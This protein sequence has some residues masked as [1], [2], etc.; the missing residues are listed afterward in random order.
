MIN[1]EYENHAIFSVI[2]SYNNLYNSIFKR[3]EHE[4][5]CKNM[6]VL[7]SEYDHLI[8]VTDIVSSLLRRIKWMC[9]QYSYY[10]YIDV[11]VSRYQVVIPM[12][13][14]YSLLSIISPPKYVLASFV[15]KVFEMGIKG[16]KATT[17]FIPS[18][19]FV[20]HIKYLLNVFWNG[21]AF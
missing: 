11:W 20:L 16:K 12:Y 4:W 14:S 1:Q 9:K 3:P 18:N 13:V 8:L 17:Y 10:S 6:T 5:K 2:T 7:W 15:Y 19:I 21:K